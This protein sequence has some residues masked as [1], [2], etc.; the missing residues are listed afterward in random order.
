[1]K[2]IR[3]ILLCTVAGV[4]VLTACTVA[5]EGADLQPGADGSDNIS[6]KVA[7]MPATR[8]A[9]LTGSTFPVEQQF[10]IYAWQ[11]GSSDAPLI[12]GETVSYDAATTLWRTAN[13]YYWPQ[14]AA[15]MDFFAVHPSTTVLTPA[16]TCTIDNYTVPTVNSTQAD[17]MYATVVGLAKSGTTPTATARTVALNFHHALSRIGFTAATQEEG[18]QVS[19]TS[20]T[21]CHLSSTET[22]TYPATT[23]GTGS[24]TTLNTAYSDYSL[25]MAEPVKTLTTTQTNLAATDGDLLMIPQTQTAWTVGSAPADCYVKIGCSIAIAGDEP[26]ISNGYVYIPLAPAWS[27]GQ[28]YLYSLRFGM[29]YDENGQVVG[30][31]QALNISLQLYDWTAGQTF[32]FDFDTGHI[33][34]NALFPT[35]MTITDWAAGGEPIDILIGS[36]IAVTLG[37]IEGWDVGETLNVLFGNW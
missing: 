26:L 34:S 7:A 27:P 19:V 6:Y 29:G 14:G 13:S 37:T 16:A 21:I 17:V 32:D 24:W 30:D 1:M 23:D 15:A 33:T 11:Q 22:F 2:T 25:S 8:G 20:I 9:A 10:A 5:S 12:G 36:D 28:Y 4:A 31:N 3:D 35:T 18:L